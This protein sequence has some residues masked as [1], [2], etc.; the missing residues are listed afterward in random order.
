MMDRFGFR[1]SMS[2]LIKLT[3]SQHLMQCKFD[4]RHLAQDEFFFQVTQ[5]SIL[6][7]DYDTERYADL[8][9]KGELIN[10]GAKKKA[11]IPYDYDKSE[12][13]EKTAAKS[14]ISDL[15]KEIRKK[16]NMPESMTVPTT[17]NQMELIEAVSREISS[18][19]NSNLLEIRI[20][21]KNANNSLYSFLNKQDPLYQFYKHLGL[22]SNFKTPSKSLVAY[23]DSSDSE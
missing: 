2:R 19:A 8:E 17:A 21:V 9:S 13:K 23:S 20:Q 22:K 14:R 3:H 10:S 11:A 6:E 7:K 12:R 16:Y 1:Y 5:K 15:E 18:A 4:V